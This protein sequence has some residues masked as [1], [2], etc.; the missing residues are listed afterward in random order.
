LK[1]IFASIVMAQIFTFGLLLHGFSGNTSQT[2]AKA[3]VQP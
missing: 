3:Y 2:P 1:I